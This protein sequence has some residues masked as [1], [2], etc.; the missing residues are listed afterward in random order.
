M[1]VARVEGCC[2]RTFPELKM[3]NSRLR[4]RHEKPESLPGSQSSFIDL[5]WSDFGNSETGL[6]IPSKLDVEVSHV[7]GVVLNELSPR[8]NRIT[9]QNGKDQIRFHRVIDSYFQQSTFVW[10]HGGFPK[11]FRIHLA[12]TFVALNREIF[13]GR[14]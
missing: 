10:I 12:Q 5:E 6:S 14:E 3:P 1:R 9:H 2:F 8:L 7:E 13:L 4:L 11:L